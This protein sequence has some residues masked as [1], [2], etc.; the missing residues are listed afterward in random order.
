[1][2]KK[3]IIEQADVGA[4]A[5]AIGVPTK[6]R[7]GK[8]QIICPGHQ[9]HTGHPDGNFGSCMLYGHGYYCFTS[10]TYTDVITMVQEQS[11][12]NGQKMSTTEAINFICQVNGFSYIPE[13]KTGPTFPFT[14]EELK[15]IGYKKP[16]VKKEE[17]KYSFLPE[18]VNGKM[19]RTIQYEQNIKTNTTS[20]Y[21]YFLSDPEQCLNMIENRIKNEIV[22]TQKVIKKVEENPIFLIEN[23]F[24]KD[25]DAVSFYETIKMHLIKLQEFDKHIFFEKRKRGTGH[26]INC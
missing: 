15:L 9:K 18:D 20:L 25:A 5:A 13:K 16:D 19:M 1:M 4:V 17:I 7:G 22:K 24:P 8:T 10:Q 14:A 2:T 11:E 23:G 26:A 6:I 3:E 12:L 21:Q